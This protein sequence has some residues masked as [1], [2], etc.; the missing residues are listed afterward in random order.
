MANPVPDGYYSAT[1]SLTIK[2]ASQAIE[3]YKKIFDAKETH[4]F[5]GPDGKSIMHAEIKIG[6]STIMLCDEMPEMGILSPT[7]VGN[8]T[9][10]IYLYVNDADSTFNKAVSN[11]A[12]PLIPMMDGFWG[13][14]WV[15]SLILLD[16]GG[17]LQHIQKI[18]AQ[19]KCKRLLKN[20]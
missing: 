14:E 12:K 2:G 3:F 13:A 20:S 15:R 6:N 1:P 10:G 9:S 16:I 5:P 18:W 4:R 8:P 19:K 17:L 7:S 11:G